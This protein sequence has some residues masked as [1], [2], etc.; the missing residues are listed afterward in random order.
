[1]SKNNDNPSANFLS[2]EKLEELHALRK[3]SE[4]ATI[5]VLLYLIII[6]V[7]WKA[8]GPLKGC[9]VWPLEKDILLSIGMGALIVMLGLSVFMLGLY[10]CMYIK[11]FI[12]K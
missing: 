2:E 10:I 8:I 11:T 1:M 4:K 3:K 12:W 5:S 9:A 6:W 7:A